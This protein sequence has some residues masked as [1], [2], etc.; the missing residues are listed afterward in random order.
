MQGNS[1]AVLLPCGIDAELLAKAITGLPSGAR[2]CCVFVLDAP[3]GGSQPSPA[4]PPKPAIGSRKELIR[5]AVRM[6]RAAPTAAAGYA[7]VMETFKEERERFGIWPNEGAL[8]QWY[9]RMRRKVGRAAS[10]RGSLAGA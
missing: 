2:L 10:V 8:K 1:S 6:I 7:Q 5:E 3:K 9:Q 4:D